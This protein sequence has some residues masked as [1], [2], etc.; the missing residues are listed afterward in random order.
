MEKKK[1]K[2]GPDEK[3]I[4]DFVSYVKPFREKG[5]KLIPNFRRRMKLQKINIPHIIDLLMTTLGNL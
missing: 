5:K 1:S 2:F 4:T 3:T